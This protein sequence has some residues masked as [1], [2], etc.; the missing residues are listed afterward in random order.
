MKKLLFKA[1][2]FMSE[3]DILHFGKNNKALIFMFICFLVGTILGSMSAGYINLETLDILN[4]IFLSDFKQRIMQNGIEVFVSSLSLYFLFALILEL[5]ALA[6]WGVVSIP[7]TIC[8][9]G[10]GIGLSG[11]YLYMIYGLK[12]IAFYILILVPGIVIS[13]IAFIFFAATA[14]KNS[15]AIAKRIIPKFGGNLNEWNAIK[16]NVKRFGYCTLV[17]CFSSFVDMCFMMMFSAFFNF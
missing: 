14:F 3:N 7:L 13:S 17:L 11:G 8:F 16:L 9:K 1:K 15:A 4:S 6:V 12:G 2:S 10:L 5:S